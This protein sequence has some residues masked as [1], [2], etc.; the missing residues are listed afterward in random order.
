MKQNGTKR[1]RNEEDDA[2]L[3]DAV[4]EY[5]ESL[6]F[7]LNRYVRNVGVAEELAEDAFVSMLLHPYRRERAASVKT[8]LFTI[9]RNKALNYLKKQARSKEVPLEE[10]GDLAEESVLEERLLRQERA[11]QVNAVL[12]ELHEEYRTVLH[13][14]YFEELSLKE[15]GEVMRKNAKQMEN[16]AYRAKKAMKQTL[17][18]EGFRYEE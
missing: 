13:L 10:A 12:G 9:G 1:S 2:V 18:K 8:Y 17:E 14:L 16:L 15:A 5:R 6:I 7:F 11:K 3:Q 4:R